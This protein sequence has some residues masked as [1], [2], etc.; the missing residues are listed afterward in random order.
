MFALQGK[1]DRFDCSNFRGISLLNAVGKMYRRVL[2]DR[3]ISLTDGVLGEKKCVF[4]SE[5]LCVDKLL[6]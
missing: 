1:K 5:R 2:I 6:W 4:L 3:I